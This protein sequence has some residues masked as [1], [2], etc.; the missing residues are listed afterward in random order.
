MKDIWLIL[1]SIG[2]M[3]GVFLIIS[4]S[5]MKKKHW[6]SRKL[7][8]FL[9]LC[10][11]TLLI[12]E[13]IKILIPETFLHIF[14][15]GETIP[16]LIGP[17]FLL[18][19]FS[20]F[21]PNFQL[22][23]KHLFHFVPFAFFFIL[24][25]PFYLKSGQYKSEYLKEISHTGTPLTSLIFSWFK[26]AH[27]FF[28]L[29]LSWFY[30]YKHQ[31]KADV[32]KVNYFNI[33]LI[34]RLVTFQLITV[35]VIYLLVTLEFLNPTLSIEPDRISAL[36]FTFSYFLFAFILVLYPKSLTPDD[37]QIIKQNKYRKSPL[38]W[39]DKRLI[40]KNL[41]KVLSEEKPYLNPKLSLNQLAS[42]INT[43]SNLLSQVINELLGKNFFQLINEY[44]INEIKNN[45]NDPKKTLYGIALDSGFNSKSAFNR[46]FKNHTGLT[47]SQYKKNHKK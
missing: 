2:I 4:L 37:K 44:R 35:V 28:Y 23:K 39:E 10:P 21:N 27:S 12:Q 8:L 22:K 32:K 19:I 14:R 46:I 24:F 34:Q 26:G 17:L 33:L 38:S 9:L 47:P 25:L 29:I 6:L 15:L 7:L 40:L 31:K 11:L 3:Q 20:V 1:Y 5:L 43:N 36:I 30:I 18:Y 16:L 45:I 13:S 41:E 42:M